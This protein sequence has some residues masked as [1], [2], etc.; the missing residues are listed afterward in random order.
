MISPPTMP[1]TLQTL[2]ARLQNLLTPASG[3]DPADL[4]DPD[5]TVRWRAVRALAGHPQADLV[6]QVLQLLTDPDPTIRFEAVRVLSAWDPGFETLQP[7]V[8]LLASDP[9]AETA[10]AILDLLSE[11]PLPSVH[12]L[13]RERLKHADPTVRAAAV[14]ALAAYDEPADVERLAALTDDPAPEVCRT[15]CLALGEV[16]DPTVLPVLRRHLQDPDFLT[17]QIVQQAIARRQDARHKA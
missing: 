10:I 6:P 13:V 16:D 2:S 7:A 9:P 15:A 3:I 8:D 14:Q 11:L 17:R 12:D 1:N 5:P 4:A